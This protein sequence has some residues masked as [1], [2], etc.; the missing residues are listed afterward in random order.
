MVTPVLAGLA[1]FGCVRQPQP[2]AIPPIPILSPSGPFTVTKTA[3]AG[4]TLRIDFTASVNPDCTVRGIPTVR[5]L[6][7]PAHGTAV[8]S[9]T[10]DYTAYPPINPRYACNKTKSRGAKLEYTPAPGY[11][12]ADYLSFEVISAEGTDKT[13]N[14]QIAVK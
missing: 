4:Q 11:A 6:A 7:Q 3:L 12:G 8:I 9:E 1:L 10:E 13:F 14:T 5:I 2:P